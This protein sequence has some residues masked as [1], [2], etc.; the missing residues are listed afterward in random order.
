MVNSTITTTDL[1]ASGLEAP[2]FPGAEA[3]DFL[4]SDTIEVAEVRLK[5]SDIF[6]ILY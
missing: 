1:S 6:L 5:S 2:N 3:K 4:P